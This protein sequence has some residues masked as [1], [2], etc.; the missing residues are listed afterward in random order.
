[1]RFLAALLACAA[2]H[3]DPAGFQVDVP[4]GWNVKSFR[5][6]TVT[7][8]SPGNG[9]FVMVS[10]VLGRESDCGGLLRG[11]LAAWNTFPDVSGLQVNSPRKGMA[12]ARFA[13]RGGVSRGAV[14]C[15]ATGPRSAMFYSIAAPAGEFAASRARLTG[16]LKS[17]RYGGV[18]GGT[19]PEALTP[20]PAMERWVEASENAFQ[21]VKPAG[22][23]AEGGV[24]RVSN[25]DVRVGY[26]LIRPDGGAVIFMGDT[27]MQKCTVAGPQ[28]VYATAANGFCPYRQGGQI[29][30]DYAT[31][32]VGPELRI[33]GLRIT[34][35]RARPELVAMADKAMNA[36]GGNV[37]NS[38]G[39]VAFEGKLGGTP[40]RG[41]ILGNTQFFPTVAPELVAGTYTQYVTGFV[42]RASE[43]GG[44]QAALAKVH[45][46]FRW[47]PRWIGANN[48]AAARDAA[49]IHRYQQWSAELGRQMFEERS[50]AA[51]RRSRSVGNLLTGQVTVQDAEGRRY[52]A[53]SGSNYYYAEE[54]GARAGDPNTA[55]FGSDTWV[56]PNNGVIDLRPLEVVE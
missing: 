25:L 37:R 15:A 4:Q 18:G 51:D 36:Q 29:A 48:A 33:E 39:E 31:R 13:Y 8:T 44:V 19:G 27:R 7:V 28:A 46:S 53:K 50:E 1:M 40:V 55:I 52:Q 23:R 10:P 41:V 34:G 24:L 5:G 17:F 45:A 43:Y 21:S 11:S 9:S 3:R 26:R 16:V 2:V 14:L 42:A 38:Y 35:R 49:A 54:E 20:A 22:W 56:S 47:N 6:G 32:A 12:V 30:E